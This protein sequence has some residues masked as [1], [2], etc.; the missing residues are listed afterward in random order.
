M[1]GDDYEEEET[2]PEMSLPLSVAMVASKALSSPS[3]LLVR[4]DPSDW[5]I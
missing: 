1:A 3:A 2:R 5:V 4:S